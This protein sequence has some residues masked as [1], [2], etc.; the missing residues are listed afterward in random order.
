MS[1][2]PI[3]GLSPPQQPKSE[4]DDLSRINQI[5]S[6]LKNMNSP[7]QQQQQQQQQQQGQ[8]QQQQQ[9][10]QQQKAL[11]EFDRY[12]LSWLSEVKTGIMISSYKTG[13]VFSFGVAQVP[14]QGTKMS[15]YLSSFNRPMGIHVDKD[16][17]FVASSGNLW[18]YT[19]SGAVETKDL[20]RFDANYVPKWVMFSSDVDAHDLTVDKN[21]QVY[22][23]SS[24]FSCICIPSHD[25]SFKAF[26]KPPWITKIAAEDRCHLNGMCARDGEVRYV[27]AVSQTDI[28]GGWRE[29]R[30]GKGVVYDIKE[31]R[32]VCDGLTMAH[33]PRWFN[34][35][36]WLLEAGTG[37]FGYVNDE[38]RF[39]RKTFI[40]GFARGLSFVNERYALVGCSQDRHESVFQ[41]L[42]IGEALKKN[43]VTAKCAVYVIDLQN[44]D[45][46]HNILFKD[47]IDELY[48]VV[49]VPG[50][51]R[52]KLA[53][54]T[55]D[56]NLREYKLD[57][58]LIE[59]ANK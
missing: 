40:P 54:P 20:G 7:P 49:A 48:D 29:N 9:Q 33:S 22:F 13:H 6:T 41:G 23:V 57:L 34:N 3:A 8:Q 2:L 53:D 11:F 24:H 12:F 25:M 35:K 56:K 39:E 38:G 5:S 46:I 45:L 50:F 14:N 4:A 15:M 42:P 28:R 17:A 31:E 1:T 10:G 52:P 58:S 43:N 26:W 30:I 18:K 55:D 44:F 37:W 51:T 19:N 21:G 59:E 47:P 27:T 36:L 32:V 16:V